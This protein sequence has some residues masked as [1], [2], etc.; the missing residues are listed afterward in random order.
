MRNATRPEEQL[1]VLDEAEIETPKATAAQI[2]RIVNVAREQVKIRKRVDTL[3]DQLKAASKELAQNVNVDL[4]KAMREAHQ[5]SCPLGDKGAYVELDEIVKASIPSVSNR[6]V[7]NAEERNAAG[8]AYMDS[9]APDMVDT[10]LTIRFP[11]GTEKELARYLRDNKRRKKPLE[12]DLTRT[13][14]TGQLSA[15]VRRELEAG[16]DVDRDALNVHIIDVAEVKVPKPK[17]STVL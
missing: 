1:P 5:T 12:L 7:E 17:K 16:R 15:W 8:I 9:R 4:P 6:R 14:H 11:K 3:S 13:V 2:A 10:V